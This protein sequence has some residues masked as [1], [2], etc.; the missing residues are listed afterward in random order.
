MKDRKAMCPCE[1]GL[2]P[3]NPGARINLNLLSKVFVIFTESS[4]LTH[5]SYFKAWASMKLQEVQALTAQ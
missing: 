3:Q 5:L 4:T 2:E 1:H